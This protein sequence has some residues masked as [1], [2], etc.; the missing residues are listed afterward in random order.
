MTT[1]K[2]GKRQ[3]FTLYSGKYVSQASRFKKEELREALEA[4]VD[5]DEAVKSGRL[6]DTMGVELL[7]VRYS[8]GVNKNSNAG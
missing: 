1:G 2:S 6:N 8:S 3:G 5:T 4:C 7:I